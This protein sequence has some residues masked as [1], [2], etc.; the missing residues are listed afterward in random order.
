MGGSFEPSFS[1]LRHEF[2]RSFAERGEL[3]ASVCVVL[4]GRRVVDLWGGFVGPGTQA[5]WGP[6]TVTVV[7]SC[8]KGAVALCAHMLASSGV[9]TLDRPVAAYWPE[10]AQSGKSEITLRMVLNHQAGLPGVSQPI[11]PEMVYDANVMALTLAGEGPLWEPGTRTGYHPLTFGWVLS[12]VV[13]RVTGQTV[14]QFFQESIARPLGLD[15]WIGLP[16]NQAHRVASQVIPQA[17]DCGL[18]PH[19]LQALRAKEPFALA[20]WN[21]YGALRDV[22][23]YNRPETHAAEIPATIGITNARSLAMMYAPLALDGALGSVRVVDQEYVATSI[24]V[25]GTAAVDLVRGEATRYSGGFERAC[26]QTQGADDEATWPPEALGSSGRGGAVAFADPARR[27]SFAYVMNRHSDGD[28]PRAARS[29]PLIQA[30]YR[31]VNAL[32]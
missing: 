22:D 26:G 30:A 21:S 1:E 11:A 23:A 4:D 28:E 27:L 13:R 20:I 19:F 18:G 2:E 5:R 9:L 17:S 15:F 25:D 3:G 10:F 31:A 7:F 24:E 29:Q 12:E 14:A 32:P 6:E 8:T 16:A